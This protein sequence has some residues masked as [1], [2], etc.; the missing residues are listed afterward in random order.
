MATPSYVGANITSTDV[1]IG[2]GAD[3]TG[4]LLGDFSADLENPEVVFQ[5][6]YGGEIGAAVN[7]DP[8]L[9]YSVDGEV[10]DKDAGLNVATFTAAVSLANVD[11]FAS[12]TSSHHGLDFASADA[13]LIG[14]SFSQPR[15]GART[16]SLNIR[17]PIGFAFS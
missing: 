4:I 7:Y 3:E 9:N 10:S 16:L 13:R 11:F 14:A 2:A 15:S 17:R 5:D 1:T 12:A 6:R 8:K